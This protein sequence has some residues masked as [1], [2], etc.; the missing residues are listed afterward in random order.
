V[1]VPDDGPKAETKRPSS[2]RVKPDEFHGATDGAFHRLLDRQP[3]TERMY[4]RL[5]EE[6]K[7]LEEERGADS[8]RATQPPGRVAR[9]RRFVVKVAAFLT[10]LAI[11]SLTLRYL[12]SIFGFD[13]PLLGRLGAPGRLFLTNPLLPLVPLWAS[14]VAWGVWALIV[15]RQKR[16]TPERPGLEPP[17]AK[18]REGSAAHPAKERMG[19]KLVR[20]MRPYLPS[21]A[22]LFV[23]SLASVPLTLITPLPI[24]L[25]VDNIIGSEP[26]PGYVAWL[27]PNPS[28]ASKETVMTIAI[29]IL[30][31]ATVLTNLQNLAKSWLTN[32]VGNRM[33]LDMRVRLFR[34]L[35]RLSTAYHDTKGTT[36]STYR[37]QYDA[38]ALR[39]LSTEIL[40]PL[41]TAVLTL[42]GMIVIMA[43]LDWQ[44]ALIA[45]VVAPFM[46]LFTLTYRRRIRV[47]WRKVKSSESAAMSAAQE[48]LSASRVVKAYGQ[49]DR[50]NEQFRSRY[51]K[52][53][54]AALKVT[55]DEGTYGLIVGVVTAIGLA[56]VL[57]IGVQH[58]QANT[59]ST[60]GLLMVYYYLTQ[61]Y[62]PLKDVGKKVLDIQKSMA[63]ME[64]FLEILDEKADVPEKPDARALAR[65]S[66]RIGFEGV[67]FG[68]DSSRLVLHDLSFD[69]PPGTCLGIVGPTG[70]G[71]TTLANLLVRFFD[72]TAGVIT[73][74]GT[75][76]RDYKVADL[77]SQFAVV[78]QDTL[79]FSTTI[80]ENIRFAKPNATDREIA[81][82]A[83]L[84]NASE[85]I[86]SLP[87]GYDTQV[88]DRG[89]KLSGGERQRISLARAFLRDAPILI[90]DEPTS[91]LDLRTEA[92]VIDAIHRLMN[93][94]TTLMIA[95]RPSTLRACDAL[96]FLEPDGVGRLTD[97][98]AASLQQLAAV[99]TEGSGSAL[100]GE[101]SL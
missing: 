81:A 13:P 35:Q 16:P 53:A 22:L 75:D 30:L 14:V 2:R 50:A 85:F 78:L 71:K 89:M 100:V 28:V 4:Q 74:D 99:G 67:S 64:R 101:G 6:L 17:R 76:L 8:G 90:L 98:V 20:E 45:L 97:E 42:G 15:A 63:G 62:T 88:G 40:V 27:L 33:D 11:V 48:S 3:A 44:L 21:I 58:V 91:S 65:A 82:A 79:L 69:L 47:G 55:V 46:F 7:R 87:D 9:G 86:T 92:S 52:T 19:Q 18:A 5:L 61:L 32:R 10:G 66:G 96:L 72:P 34:Q 25:I 80:A 84:A 12:P 1:T 60:G 23:A 37:I 43:S 95:H 49:E 56:A 57:F 93:G 83:K 31:G 73:L 68:Y 29:G 24:K 70:S 38:T 77:R 51:T 54:S 41:V 94:R 39:A 36:D 26:L 59:L